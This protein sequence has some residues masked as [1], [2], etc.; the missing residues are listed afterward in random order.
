VSDTYKTFVRS[1][2]NWSEFSSAK[3]HVQ[4]TGLT[5]D[6]AKR[7]C[8]AY[9]ANLTPSEK[10]TKMEFT[11]ES[12]TRKAIDQVPLH[13]FF[14]KD[15]SGGEPDDYGV[16]AGERRKLP[17]GSQGGNMLLTKKSYERVKRERA[18][19][20]QDTPAWE[21]LAVYKTES[22]KP[23]RLRIEEMMSAG[24]VTRLANEQAEKAARRKQS[25][26]VFFDAADIEKN[27]GKIPNIGSY[28]PT[29]W[30]LV[31]HHM[32]DK[33]GMG[34]EDEPA[35]TVKGY[36]AWLSKYLETPETCGW[37]IIEEGQFQVV[38]GRFVKQVQRNAGPSPTRE[39]I[40]RM[41]EDSQLGIPGFDWTYGDIGPSD[42]D[43]GKPANGGNFDTIEYTLPEYWASYL[44]NGDA[45]GLEDGEQEEIDAWLAKEGNPNI[46][47]C[48]EEGYF[49]RYCDAPGQLA[50]NMLTYTALVP[51]DKNYPGETEESPPG[52]LESTD[53]APG[54][55]G[56]VAF[57]KGKKMDVYA[58]SSYAAQKKA[59]AAFGA[60]KSYEVNVVLAEKPDGS[61]VTHVPEGTEPDW[62]EPERTGK[63]PA[64]MR[65]A[66]AAAM[67][68]G[69][70]DGPERHR[71]K[72][73]DIRG[74]A[75]DVAN[76]RDKEAARPMNKLKRFLGFGESIQEAGIASGMKAGPEPRGEEQEEEG[77]A[78]EQGYEGDGTPQDGADGSRAHTDKGIE[79]M[80]FQPSDPKLLEPEPGQHSYRA[81]WDNEIAYY[82]SH[83]QMDKLEELKATPEQMKAF[84]RVV[85]RWHK[86]SLPNTLMGDPSCLMVQV[87]GEPSGDNM[88]GYSMWLGIEKDGYTH[89]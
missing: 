89:S 29:G 35:L 13:E 55:H 83:P 51:K 17:Y 28:R 25:P 43:A 41:F 49:S 12:A 48:S 53:R 6:E 8:A 62:H 80:Q 50:G 82:L 3:K 87:W 5:Y 18:E 14:G 15:S 16:A 4:D 85:R 10:G 26:R 65:L 69:M 38:V 19:E 47:D 23:R 11:A 84:V 79:D 45:S 39:S 75:D 61:Q 57:Y 37:A 56:Y 86:V 66:T 24:E 88:E 36:K 60:K 77:T 52:A 9:N 54:D 71:R 76:A 27:F 73:A 34:A 32:V 67:L 63:P 44:I 22:A 78:R 21:T 68:Q 72:S 20:G 30:E 58:T 74:R 33:S 31:E 46:V 1:A 81:G 40:D 59:A 42:P 70:P 64:S 7:A 2:S